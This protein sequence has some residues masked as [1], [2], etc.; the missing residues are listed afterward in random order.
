MLTLRNCRAHAESATAYNNRYPNPSYYRICADQPV[1][2]S[3]CDLCSNK[4]NQNTKRWISDHCDWIHRRCQVH[5]LDIYNFFAHERN[6][7][8]L[9]D[10]LLVS[11]SNTKRNSDPLDRVQST[12]SSVTVLYNLVLGLVFGQIE[13]TGSKSEVNWHQ[14]RN[15]TFG[16]GR[17]AYGVQGAQPLSQASKVFT[18]RVLSLS[19]LTRSTLLSWCL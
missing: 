17:A 14:F 11:V 6:K 5:Q 15:F 1:I 12:T 2:L 16:G 4:G 18:I 3:A 10:L 8:F 13:M 9:D 19:R 7:R